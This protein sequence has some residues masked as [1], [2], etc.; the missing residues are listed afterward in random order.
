MAYNHNN[1]IRTLLFAIVYSLQFVNPLII[2]GQ[3]ELYTLL[4]TN[5]AQIKLTDHFYE[6]KNVEV[7]KIGNISQ[8]GKKLVIKY[9][10]GGYYMDVAKGTTYDRDISIE[11]DLSNSNV[12]APPFA[13]NITGFKSS[14]G[15]NTTITDYCYNWTRTY[16]V[17][18]W[19]IDCGSSALRNRVADIF[20]GYLKP[21]L[22][23]TD[24]VKQN[25]NTPQES[26]SAKKKKSPVQTKKIKVQAPVSPPKKTE[27]EK[28]TIW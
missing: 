3:S 23:K 1:H 28:E 10:V 12:Y 11:I 17:D 26:S 16:L 13:T 15:I 22:P 9:T 18:T 5:I 27:P 24:S 14:K 4:Q 20:D 19:L 2:S 8:I 7:K 6:N 25:T 21:Y